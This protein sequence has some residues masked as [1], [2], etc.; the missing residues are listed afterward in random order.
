MLVCNL[1]PQP[2]T[3]HIQ[4][5]LEHSPRVSCRPWPGALAVPLLGTWPREC[6]RT[7]V[8]KELLAYTYYPLDSFWAEKYRA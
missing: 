8:R 2:A 6:R 3:G 7:R 5:V 1:V 4:Q